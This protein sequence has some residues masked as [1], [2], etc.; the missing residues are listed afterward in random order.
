M[1]YQARYYN[2]AIGQFT[3]PDTHTPP[4]PPGLNRHAYT[5]GNPIAYTDPSGHE[6]CRTV[7]GKTFYYSEIELIHRDGASVAEIRAQQEFAGKYDNSPYNDGNWCLGAIVCR[8]YQ[9]RDGRVRFEGD[10]VLRNGFFNWVYDSAAGPFIEGCL[11]DSPSC[12]ATIGLLAVGPGISE[13]FA[14]EALTGDL[15]ADIGT[16]A[17]TGAP[18]GTGWV[19]PEGG[20]GATINGRWFTEHALERM[21]PTTPQVMA[22]LEARA[23]ARAEAAGLRTGTPEFAEWWAKYGPAPRGVPP[24]VV[25]AEILSPGSTSVRVITKANGDVVTVIQR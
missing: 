10:P 14:A 3:Q 18:S 11:S 25:E 6:E 16:L 8:I 4:G 13:A 21:A 22:E 5:N 1:Y 24:S 12:W 17:E 15:E 9:I 23:L 20:G 2:P 19:P 7:Q